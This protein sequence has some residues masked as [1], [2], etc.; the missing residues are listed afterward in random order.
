MLCKFEFSSSAPS[1][2]YFGASGASFYYI[3]R[4]PT[5]CVQVGRKDALGCP[6]HLKPVDN[7][8]DPSLDHH[9]HPYAK[10]QSSCRKDSAGPPSGQFVG[11]K[12]RFGSSTNGALAV[13]HVKHRSAN[14]RQHL[15]RH[16]STSLPSKTG[17][18]K[19]HKPGI[20]SKSSIING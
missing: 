12:A 18:R 8:N 2:W 7:P 4:S 20:N 3:V 13:K 14:L 10:L 11:N 9:L 5:L 1:Q 15:I 16:Q 6:S 19:A 17:R